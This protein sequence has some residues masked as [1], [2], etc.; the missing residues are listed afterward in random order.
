MVRGAT[1]SEDLPRT[2]SSS[3]YVCLGAV[4]VRPD[5]GTGPGVS[6]SARRSGVVGERKEGPQ[7][8]R[9]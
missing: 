5:P 6:R 7:S 9:E 1:V 3:H 8:V 4:P 2:L